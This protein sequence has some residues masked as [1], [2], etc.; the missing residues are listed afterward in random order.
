MELA[1]FERVDR[2]QS[3]RQ[4]AVRGFWNVRIF[5]LFLLRVRLLSSIPA[6]MPISSPIQT[7]LEQL[8][9][10]YKGL[11][12]G[13]VASYIPDLMKADPDWFGICVVTFDG[14]VYEVGDT[15]QPF[16]I[17]SISKP[18]AYGIALEDSGN[19]KVLSKIWMEPS[20]EAF[21]SIS[22][23]PSG[24]PLNPMI[25]A[26]A[27]ATTG[28]IRGYTT[29][30]KVQRILEVFSDYVGHELEIDESVCRSESETGH[31][32]RAIAY[33]LR[34]FDV[35]TDD[36]MPSLEVYFKQCS[37]LIHCRDL[38]FIGATLANDG[39]HP[40]TARRAVG[41]AHIES[42]LS[43]MA[44]CG[45]YDAAGEWLYS[46][47]MPAKSGVGGG[48][49]A[50]LPGQLAVAVF[51]PPLD[52]RGNSARG[53]AVCRELSTRYNLHLFNSVMPS[54]SVIRHRCTAAQVSSNRSRPAEEIALLNKYGQSIHLIEVQGQVTFGPAERV[55]RELI[56]CADSAFAMILDFS[57]VPQMD[58]VASQIFLESLAALA[59]KGLWIHVTRSHHLPE[60][61]CK[62][63]L[64]PSNTP[65]VRLCWEEDAD[66]AL[67]FCENRLL[68]SLGNRHCSSL[69]VS[70]ENCELF[71]NLSPDELKL[72]SPML[73]TRSFA[74]GDVIFE[75]GQAASEMLI[76]LQ[77]KVSVILTLPNGF[78]YRVNT[79]T[80]GMT[81]GEMGL[82]DRSPRSATVRADTSILAL[83][84][85]AE[86][87]EALLN[88]HPLIYA[89]LLGN[90]SRHLAIRLRKRNA[91]V[92]NSHL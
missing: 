39:V 7:F 41:S 82:L 16:T 73:S 91:E 66:R 10:Q 12:E 24:R 42:M 55:I 17:Q 6:K 50:V 85:S 2:L 38:A 48:I 57:R 8:H 58:A 29:E 4:V 35:F 62:S 32:N 25:N 54:R 3:F 21:N 49:L 60:L 5:A 36:P 28:L 27:I 20:G 51:S 74:A 68:E 90:I 72:L 79:C 76:I 18:L 75:E 11:R 56:A 81:F 45:M 83:S 64:M 65:S 89:K 59:E 70:M 84:L 9:N 44:S 69:A 30:Q 15:R 37:I 13:K 61:S 19:E 43:V 77:G 14:Q 67:E 63:Q 92:I 52:E 86:V 71:E 34:N 53:I 31:R 88:E 40:I 22:L 47:G 26:G 80:P 87:F 78:T 1:V 33:M 46:V 23:D